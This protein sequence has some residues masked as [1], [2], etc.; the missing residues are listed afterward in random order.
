VSGGGGQA[1]PQAP[2]A[3]TALLGLNVFREGKAFHIRVKPGSE[4]DPRLL[5]AVAACPAGLYT[6]GGDGRVELGRDGCLEC[7]ACWLLCGPDVLEWTYPE[8][9]AGVQYR[10]G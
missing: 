6:V 1:A 10:F 2:G 5:L 3:A 9:A 7:G 8:G 4:G